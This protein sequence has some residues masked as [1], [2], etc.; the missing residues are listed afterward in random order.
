MKIP[1]PNEYLEYVT[2]G[3]RMESLTKGEPGYF[4]LWPIAEIEKM[5]A[6][7]QVE[8]FMAGFV[9]FGSDGGGEM[10]AFDETGAVWKLPF[11]GCSSKDDAWK[12]ADHWRSIAERISEE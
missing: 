12:I 9:G 1:I 5:N 6:E 10:L 7:Y 4:V 3:G 8:E 2:K 11:V